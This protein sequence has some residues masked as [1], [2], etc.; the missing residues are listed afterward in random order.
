[1][2]LRLGTSIFKGMS[3]CYLLIVEQFEY[4]KTV[5]SPYKAWN[6]KTEP[7]SQLYVLDIWLLSRFLIMKRVKVL[8]NVIMR[9]K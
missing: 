2:T 4:G 7:E 1:M 3:P 9:G 5:G 6:Y 8:L